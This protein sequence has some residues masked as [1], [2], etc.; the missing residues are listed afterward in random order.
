MR[1]I[2]IC[3]CVCV[4]ALAA[5]TAR[6]DETKVVAGN[7]RFA[8]ALYRHVG[9]KAGNVFFSPS[10]IHTALAMTYAG[11]RGTT[12][13]EMA[14]A[15]HYGK[16][17]RFFKDYGEFLRAIRPAKDAPYELRVANSLWVQHDQALRAP[18]VACNREHFGVGLFDVDFKTRA[19]VIRGRINRWVEDQTARKIKALLPAGALDAAT[20][21]VLAN[22]IYFKGD[23][24]RQFKKASTRPMDFH[25]SPARTV[26]VPMMR[27]QARFG[28]TATPTLQALKMPYKG[29]ELSMVVLLPKAGVALAKVEASLTEKSLGELVGRLGRSRKVQVFFPRFEM[30]EKM[31]MRAVLSKMGMARAFGAGADFSG[32]TPSRELCI[33]DVF[34]KAFVKVDEK[35]TEAAAATAVV[36]RLTAAPARP[37]VFKA[38]RPFCFL[39]RHEA[40][41]AILFLGRLSD[42]ATP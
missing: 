19:E 40:T 23:W 14:R 16:G 42:P 21:M 9:A 37:I 5:A 1:R 34:H 25:V 2:A 22:A 31:Q 13:E 20:R 29:K 36:M 35:G 10:S 7:N 12:A 11:A 28:Y 6:A 30:T 33:S 4:G 39:I 15:L 41:G 17:E 8:L 38:D 3:V 32:M 24:L 18:F 26:K 27:Q